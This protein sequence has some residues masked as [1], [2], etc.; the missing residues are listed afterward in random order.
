MASMGRIVAPSVNGLGNWRWGAGR[1]IT[2]ED[3]VTIQFGLVLWYLN[4]N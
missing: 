1:R 3:A 2:F 4:E